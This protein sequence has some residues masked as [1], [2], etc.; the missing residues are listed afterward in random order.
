MV[1]LETAV[2]LLS[3]MAKF[4]L[5]GGAAWRKKQEAR[6]AQGLA[7][8]SAVQEA[9]ENRDVIHCMQ[10]LYQCLL[11]RRPAALLEVHLTPEVRCLR[12][13][14][15][16]DA[17]SGLHALLVVPRRGFPFQLFRA[18]RGEDARIGS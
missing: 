9:A 17:L 13:R 12:F 11:K 14:I 4:L 16:S 6:A 3:L 7:R 8:S 5:Y 15:V 18:E 2:L 1:M 10:Q